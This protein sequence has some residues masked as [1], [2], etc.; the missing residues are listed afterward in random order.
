MRIQGHEWLK[1]GLFLT[2]ALLVSAGGS[3]V[4]I[5]AAAADRRQRPLQAIRKLP[6][7]SFN[8]CSNP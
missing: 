1:K 6:S 8:T 2:V 5:G 3:A 4:S 7:G